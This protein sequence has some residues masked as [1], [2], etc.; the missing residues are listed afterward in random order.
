[1]A[2]RFKEVL[3]RYNTGAVIQPGDRDKI[4]E[5]LSNQVRME[6]QSAVAFFLRDR[7]W[8][9]GRGEYRDWIG[10]G[11]IQNLLIHPGEQLQLHVDENGRKAVQKSVRRVVDALIETQPS[12]GLHLQSYIKTGESCTYA[13]SWKWTFAP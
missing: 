8:T 9:I 3:D 4:R 12:I 7:E 1:M 6:Q 10:F 11:H 5:A 2:N 13:G